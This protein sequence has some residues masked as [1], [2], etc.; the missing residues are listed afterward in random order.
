MAA[1]AADGGDSIGRAGSLDHAGSIRLR[2]SIV[3]GYCMQRTTRRKT[4]TS[5][6]QFQGF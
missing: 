2:D 5:V 1:L 4:R 3:Y 6:R